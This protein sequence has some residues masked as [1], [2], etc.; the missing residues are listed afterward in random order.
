MKRFL[1]L[2]LGSIL[3]LSLTGCGPAVVQWNGE[4]EILADL[5]MV[6]DCSDTSVYANSVSNVFVGTVVKVQKNVISERRKKH[7]DNYSVYTIRVEENLKG[8]LSGEIICSKLGGLRKDGTMLVVQAETPNGKCITDSGMPEEGRKYIFL[9]YE[10]PDGRLILSE[11]LDDR[12]YSEDLVK[13]Y[14]R[15]LGVTVLNITSD[16]EGRAL[17]SGPYGQL[18]VAI[19]DNW[20]A[21]AAPLESGKL[22]TGLYGLILKPNGVSSGQI[23]VYCTDSFGVCGTGLSEEKISLAGTTV[24]VGTY[25]DHPHWDYI[26]FGGEEAKIVA[27]HT[28]CS[29]WK[30]EMWKEALAILD[31]VQFDKT[32]RTGGVGQ[33]IPES[34]NDD[35][36][37]A[38]QV[39][40]ITSSGLTVRLYRYDSRNTAELLYGEGYVLNRKEGSE[41]VEV[42]QIIENGGFT[43]EG[44]PIPEEGEAVQKI[45][46]EWLYGKLSPGTYRIQKTVTDM[47]SR[48]GHVSIPVYFLTAQFIL[49]D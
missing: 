28:E 1:I 49:A 10:Q 3:L 9:A 16:L 23:E 39:E 24:T 41:W 32:I 17:V 25:D 33:F 44:Y 8:D 18:S 20:S 21:E 11:I 22:M 38:M 40:H 26:A 14:K 27:Q 42:P 7:E 35:I 34:E 12:E 47:R 30:D 43:D 46:W 6:V 5:L 15:A 19:P 45:D 2:L 31:T 29:T 37:V 48:E 36:A 13:E 4:K